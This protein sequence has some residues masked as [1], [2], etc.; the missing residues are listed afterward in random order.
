MQ[1]CEQGFLFWQG[2]LIFWI[3]VFR[4]SMYCIYSIGCHWLHDDNT[5]LRR[6]WHSCSQ[7]L[8]RLFQRSKLCNGCW[9][10]VLVQVK[11]MRRTTWVSYPQNMIDV[12]LFYQCH[13]GKSGDLIMSEAEGHFTPELEDP[14]LVN[15]KLSHW[16]KMLRPSYFTLH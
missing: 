11:M 2:I 15:S 12:N 5:K 13:I 14:W 4:I 9:R 16:W 10:M 3:Q 1:N 6:T 7:M 8:N